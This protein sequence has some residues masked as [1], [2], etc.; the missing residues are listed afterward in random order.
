M[1]LD[2]ARGYE[3]CTIDTS[4]SLEA[5]STAPRATMLLQQ[6]SGLSKHTLTSIC[7]HLLRPQPMPTKAI[8][9]LKP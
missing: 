6:H 9:A 3:R 8:E 2:I 4:T 1:I 7:V 5:D